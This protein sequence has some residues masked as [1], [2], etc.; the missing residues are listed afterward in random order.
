MAG[1]GIL[2]SSDPFWVEDVPASVLQQIRFDRRFLD[3]PV[4]FFL[5]FFEPLAYGLFA[6]VGIL[7]SSDPFWVEDVPASVLQQIRFD[8]RFLDPP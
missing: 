1:V 8:R 3:P 6:G 5:L 2:Y 7:Y 4:F